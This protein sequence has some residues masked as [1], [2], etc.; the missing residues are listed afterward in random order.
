MTLSIQKKTIPYWRELQRKNFTQIDALADFLELSSD[1]RE[2]V[3]DSPHFPLNIPYRLALKMKKNTLDDPLLRQFLPLKIEDVAAAHT[4]DDPLEDRR[5]RKTPKLLKKYEKRALLV[6]TGA[7]VMNCR[8]CFRKNFPYETEIP[9]F[10]N[11]IETIA[12]DSTLTEIILSGGDPLSLSDTALE[13]LFQSLDPIPHL[14]RIRFHTRFP[15]GI[16]ERIDDSFLSLL[17]SSSKQI[18]FVIHCNHPL[19]L[20][21]EVSAALKKVQKLGI[22]VLNQSVLLRGVNDREEIL[23]ELV[24]KMIDQGII[25]Y[26]LHLNDAVTGAA[27]FDVS[28]E[29]GE[30]LIAYL[31]K[32][33]S[34]YGIPRLV[35][36]IPGKMSKTRYA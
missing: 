25:P 36:E 15:I 23:L 1:L 30:E 28:K 24:E 35:R 26:Y 11:E 22:P 18:F 27:H 19:E 10:Q 34:G 5:F 7:C 21:E 2:Q 3:L 13:A 16:P 8:F 9:G 12:Q 31:E 33:L 6:S 14:K 32:Q 20:D 17:A 4:L 29:R